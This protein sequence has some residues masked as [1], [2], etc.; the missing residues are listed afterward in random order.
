VVRFT[1][2]SPP[3]FAFLAFFTFFAFFAFF[4]NTYKSCCSN[5]AVPTV[6]RALPWMALPSP[7]AVDG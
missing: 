1:P 7:T 2:S 6:V 3:P 5:R 4:I